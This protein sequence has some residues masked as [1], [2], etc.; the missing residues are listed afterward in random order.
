MSS[1]EGQRVSGI[2]VDVDQ[3][4]HLAEGAGTVDAIVSV[5]VGEDIPDLTVRLWTPAGARVVFVKQV[6][7]TL[8]DLT[9]GR[10]DS[11]IQSGEYPQGFW[12]AGEE[13]VFHIRIEVLPAVVGRE[14]LA[15]RVTAAAGGAIQGE[16]LVKAIWT[17][18]T[19]LSARINRAVAH[20]TGQAELAQVIQDGSSAYDSGDVATAAEKWRR[21][22]E[23]AVDSGNLDTARLL[24]QV[25]EID[26]QTGTVCLRREIAP[27]AELAL[28]ARSTRTARLR[29]E[30]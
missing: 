12:S 13:R 20:Y 30:S 5:A 17:A 4:P 21:A 14:K 16:G 27:E 28:D 26:E 7:P 29:K 3:N 11:G 23:L 1:T 25:I 24:R 9:H 10:V 6:V 22:L 15:A 2:A 8:E 19:A 18:D